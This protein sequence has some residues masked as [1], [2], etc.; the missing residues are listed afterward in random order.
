MIR[1]WAEPARCSA[2]CRQSRRSAG[3]ASTRAGV[4]ARE[5]STKVPH[6]T[7]EVLRINLLQLQAVDHVGQTFTAR[8]M[9]QF[10]LR[11]G[12]ANE[13]LTRDISDKE[14]EFPEDCQ[15]GAAWYLDQLDFPTA[16]Q[17]SILSRKVVTIG[18]DLHLVLKVSGRS[19]DR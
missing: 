14:P 18:P 4:S 8:Y 17:F 1:K 9:F 5:M 2:V 3:L 16:L 12:A 11:N 6:L 7:L 19:L 15:P 10:V 13:Q